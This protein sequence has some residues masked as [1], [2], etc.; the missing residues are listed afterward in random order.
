MT[1]R[2]RC[3]ASPTLCHGTAAPCTPPTKMARPLVS[4]RRPLGCGRL[5]RHRHGRREMTPIGPDHAMS[6]FNGRQS[7]GPDRRR[8]LREILQ[9]VEHLPLDLHIVFGETHRVELRAQREKLGRVPRRRRRAP[10]FP[11]L[12]QTPIFPGPPA[13]LE[14]SQQIHPRLRRPVVGCFGEAS[15][16]SSFVGHRA[17]CQVIR[18]AV[19]RPTRTARAA[20]SRRADESAP[21][22]L[23]L[24]LPRT[25]RHV[26]ACFGIE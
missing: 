10:G 17:R 25:G 18:P 5:V 20:R 12:R 11:P 4:S 9:R 3:S 15:R 1:S 23:T 6:R 13:S 26:P 19:V 14:P 24:H 2:S 21:L 16:V 8:E 7:R 22:A